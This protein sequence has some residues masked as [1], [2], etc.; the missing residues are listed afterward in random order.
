MVK[1]GIFGIGLDTYWSQFD[2]LFERLLG[3]Q[4]QIV[5]K[6]TQFGVDVIDAGMVDSA[7]KAREAGG[8][9]KKMMLNLF[10]YTFQLMPYLQR[11]CLL[12]KN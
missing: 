5:R 8:Y 2:G 7:E 9:L 4:R 12:C 6:M 3:Y 1:I 10:L 11:Y